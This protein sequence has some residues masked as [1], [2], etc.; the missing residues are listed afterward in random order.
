MLSFGDFEKSMFEFCEW[1]ADAEKVMR[2]TGEN[3]PPAMVLSDAKAAFYRLMNPIDAH[4]RLYPEDKE[5]LQEMSDHVLGPSLF[6]SEFF[7][8]ARF[9]PHGYAGDYVLIEKMYMLESWSPDPCVGAGVNLIDYLYSTITGCACL[10]DRRAR[11]ARLLLDESQRAGRELRVLDVACGGARYLRDV[12]GATDGAIRLSVTFVDQDPS[13]LKFLSVAMKSF[14]TVSTRFVCMP[15]RRLAADVLDE[16]F[17]VVISAGLYD[18][19]SPS[20]GAFLAHSLCRRVAAG[21]CIAVSNYHPEER[22]TNLRNVLSRWEL[23]LRDE[24][25]LAAMFSPHVDAV[26]ERSADG[27]LGYVFGRRT[28]TCA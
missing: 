27:G 3:V 23:I 17:D 21:G 11:L 16:E 15:I 9:R 28:S 25:E 26:T 14:S 18:Y 12:L 10:W 13:A 2:R 5:T 20:E 22:S 6:R 24:Y 4:L 8:R 7:W 1:L 19:L